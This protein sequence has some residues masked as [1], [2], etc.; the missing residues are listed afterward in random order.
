MR[1]Q[2]ETQR[3]PPLRHLVGIGPGFPDGLDGRV[4][5]PPAKVW[6]ALTDPKIHAKWWAAGDMRAKMGHRFTLDMGSFGQQPCEVLAVESERL[7]SD[8]FI[9]W[10]SP[11]PTE[12]FAPLESPCSSSPW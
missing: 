10:T 3:A 4:V 7:L 11:G 8:S 2:R 9:H 12:P 1:G 5:H 6:R